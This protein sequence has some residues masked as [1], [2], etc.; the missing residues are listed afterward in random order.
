MD[1]SIDE[2]LRNLYNL[3]LSYLPW[4]V[5]CFMVIKCACHIVPICCLAMLYTGLYVRHLGG[6]R[7][8]ELLA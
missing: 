5:L 6:L 8:P 1:K 2:I 4:R 3:D 7:L